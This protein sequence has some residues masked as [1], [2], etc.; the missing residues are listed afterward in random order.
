MSHDD[1]AG[2]PD[3]SSGSNPVSAS[4]MS[5]F[6]QVD[7]PAYKSFDIGSGSSEEI[8]TGWKKWKRGL[9]L[10]LD[11]LGVNKERE[12][13]RLKSMVLY[14]IGEGCLDIYVTINDQGSDFESVIKTLDDY[15]IPQCN[16]SYE[17]HVFGSCKQNK[18][19]TMDCYVTRLRVLAK[20][21]D[22]QDTIDE[23]IRDQVIQGCFSH[24]LRKKFLQKHD[25]TLD[26]ILTMSKTTELSEGQVRRMRNEEKVHTFYEW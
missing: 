16:I 2:P 21:C 12:K 6:V 3:V 14:L 9:I 11:A 23:R 4:S 10:Y 1:N 26:K 22:F 25:L 17:R 13:T 19:E 24:E 18:G 7:L 20:T 5:N 8:A 15:F